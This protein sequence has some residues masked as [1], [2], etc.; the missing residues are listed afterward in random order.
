RVDVAVEEV[1]PGRRGRELVLQR[2][3]TGQ[4]VLP[5]HRLRAGLVGG[6]VDVVGDAVLVLEVDGDGRLGVEL[7][8]LLV[9]LDALGRQVDGRRARLPLLGALPDGGR[10]QS[11][12][13]QEDADGAA[14]SGQ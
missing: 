1:A 10:G 9:E 13:E 11:S 3:R 14:G 8:D 7:Q 6:D 12:T 5:E 2:R 4:R